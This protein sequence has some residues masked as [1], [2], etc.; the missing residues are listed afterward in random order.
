MFCKCYW[1]RI[2]PARRLSSG[3][4]RKTNATSE[5]VLSCSTDKALL[6]CSSARRIKVY[7]RVYT[8]LLGS[9]KFAG[10]LTLTFL[11]LTSPCQCDR[12]SS[13]ATI[14]IGTNSI[15][16]FA[17]AAYFRTTR[18]REISHW[19]RKSARGTIICWHCSVIQT[20]LC[21]TGQVVEQFNPSWIRESFN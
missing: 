4:H 13:L 16:Y 14:L 9:N 3:C 19:R 2:Q 5:L 6:T 10:L 20:L 21:L 12:V 11:V 17:T 1:P 7:T 15:Y 8:S 18:G